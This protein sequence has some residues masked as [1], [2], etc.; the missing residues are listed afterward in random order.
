MGRPRHSCEKP[1]SPYIEFVTTTTS[2]TTT[3]APDLDLVKY[4]HG[5]TC[6][7]VTEEYYPYAEFN[8]DF[9]IY[10]S[11]PCTST[12]IRSVLGNQFPLPTTRGVIAN[13]SICNQSSRTVLIPQ[14]DPSSMFC[15]TTANDS[16]FVSGSGETLQMGGC[17]CDESLPEAPSTTIPPPQPTIPP[18]VPATTTTQRPIGFTVKYINH[19]ASLNQSTNTVTDTIKLSLTLT[20]EKYY[21]HERYY[22]RLQQGYLTGYAHA[23]KMRCI[24]YNT[25]VFVPF[26]AEN[27]TI[28]SRLSDDL[29]YA[30]EIVTDINIKTREA[31][32]DSPSMLNKEQVI[33]IPNPLAYS[34]AGVAPPLHKRLAWRVFIEEPVFEDVYRQSYIY[35]AQIYGHSDDPLNPPNPNWPG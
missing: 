16:T 7:D 21:N 31:G 9:D 28:G 24:P 19:N 35:A 15:I 29:D 3:T 4:A 1:S 2:T 11:N 5:S 8:K 22:V 25:S 18:N 30:N 6:Y 26:E 27:G 23:W 12:R 32:F 20:S 14:N 13:F 34:N 17:G 33:E 10:G